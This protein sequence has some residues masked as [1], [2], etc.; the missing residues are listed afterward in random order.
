MRPSIVLV[1]LAFVALGFLLGFAAT[2]DSKPQTNST[3]QAQLFDE[4]IAK[5]EN[6]AQV[7]EDEYF[8]CAYNIYS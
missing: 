5:A 8:A 3:D 2:Y 7:S 6:D 4:C 1:L